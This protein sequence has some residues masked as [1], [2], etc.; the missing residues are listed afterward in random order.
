MVR[1]PGARIA[2]VDALDDIPA[3]RE[4]TD[5]PLYSIPD[6]VRP[7]ATPRAATGKGLYVCRDGDCV[8]RLLREKK[9]RRMFIESM[10]AACILLLERLVAPPSSST[11][12]QPM[13]EGRDAHE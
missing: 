1:P 3:N 11:D 10:E 12:S 7:G 13:I 4:R 5:S 6:R 9:Y 2:W 8:A